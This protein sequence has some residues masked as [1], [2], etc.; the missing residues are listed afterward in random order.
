MGKRRKTVIHRLPE[1]IERDGGKWVCHYC[2]KK[3]IPL[4]VE[5]PTEPYYI[6]RGSGIP[7]LNTDYDYPDADHIVP[8]SKGGGDDLDNLV[9]ACRK[10]NCRKGTKSYD[11]FVAIIRRES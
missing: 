6:K 3:L 10:C 7:V 9:A 2:G 11:E 1:I 5:Y 4:D 8:Y